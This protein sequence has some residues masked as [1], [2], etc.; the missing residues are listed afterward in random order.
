MSKGGVTPRNDAAPRA[1]HRSSAFNNLLECIMKRYKQLGTMLAAGL[2]AANVHAT[3]IPET[4]AGDLAVNLGYNP[5]IAN[6]YAVTHLNLGDFTDI[7]KFRLTL[8][9]PSSTANASYAS[10]KLVDIFG[11]SNA[12]FGLYNDSNVLIQAG[13]ITPIGINQST[14]VLSSV[15]LT[16][17]NY[18]YKIT[19]DSVGTLGS[20]YLFA[21]IVNPCPEPS[22]YALMLIGL[23][24]L[25]YVGMRQARK[26]AARMDF[27]TAV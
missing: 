7:F 2:L 8:G 16:N 15:S 9:G 17:G 25:G 3:T 6:I 5:N 1:L 26:S 14:G 4:I 12:T 22:T 21:Q 11:L 19:G 18:Y 24:G 27:G 13:T 23:L 20:A 10:L